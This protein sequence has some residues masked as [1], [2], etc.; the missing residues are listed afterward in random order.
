MLLF[1]TES[2]EEGEICSPKRPRLPIGPAPPEERWVACVRLA[3]VDSDCLSQGRVFIVTAQ[4]ADIGRYY[5]CMMSSLLYQYIFRPL[6]YS[7]KF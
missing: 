4:G 6:L 7:R 1:L 5:H 2:L 3:V